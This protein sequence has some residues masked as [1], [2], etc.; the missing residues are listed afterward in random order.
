MDFDDL[1]AGMGNAL[2]RLGRRDEAAR[3][4]ARALEYNPDHAEALS[5]LGG[6][7]F[8]SGDAKGMAMMRRAVKLQPSHARILNNLSNV[9][10]FTGDHAGAFEFMQKAAKL[11]PKPT[12]LFNLAQCHLNF[13]NDR[14][15]AVEL[16][17]QAVEKAPDEAQMVGALAN[18]QFQL[19]Q[20]ERGLSSLEKAAQI[21]PAAWEEPFVLWKRRLSLLEHAP[22]VVANKF[23]PESPQQALDL[24]TAM[25]Y[26]R[27]GDL[28]G[29]LWLY[30][31]AFERAP[32]LAADQ[33]NGYR[34]NAACV[35]TLAGDREQAL[36]WLRACLAAWRQRI[37]AESN[38]IGFERQMGTLMVPT[39][40]RVEAMMR[41]NHWK[42]DPDLES[43]RGDPVL[44]RGRRGA[45]TGAAPVAPRFALSPERFRLR[46]LPPRG[47]SSVGRAVDF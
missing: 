37:T 33:S 9:L 3:A 1:Y 38:S 18:A 32:R 20:A 24:A 45:R 12:Y 11:D 30:R 19:G 16:L 31:W 4:W 46:H 21:D 41:L 13:T 14:K 5:D 27:R 35:A 44:E 7:K 22:D 34:Y 39:G 47:R 29:S 40:P 10:A 43:L 26:F 36:K 28:K 17:E 15:R 42:R 2:L 8:Y 25:Q 6:A 23:E